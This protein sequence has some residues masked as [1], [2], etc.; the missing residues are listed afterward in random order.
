MV[1][2]GVH[3]T[4]QSTKEDFANLINYL[5]SN[6]T[7]PFLVTVDMEGCIN[8]FEN[9][10]NFTSLDR[11]NTT[12]QSFQ[13]GFDEGML[14]KELNMTINF[15]PVVD[16]ND[17]IWSCR[18]FLGT[19]QEIGDKASAYISGLQSQ[20]ILATAKHYPGKTLNLRDPHSVLVYA[21]IDDNDSLP[22]REVIQT[23]VSAIMVDHVIANG[24]VDSEVKQS[25]ASKRL[26]GDL[27]TNFSG[28]IITDE[29]SMLGLSNFYSNPDQVYI[30][31]FKANNDLVLY[32]NSDRT[33]LSHAISVVEEAVKS[34]QISEKR[35]DDSVTKILSIKGINVIS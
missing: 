33:K 2:G 20:G 12:N 10:Q 28:L 25:D 23:N 9:F 19:P 24:S 17:T 11:I 26:I 35:I 34:G 30:D 4:A 13:V 29:T 31:V 1:V 3:V 27:N 5:Q 16:L 8:P 6:A 32:L 14:M 21:T 15:S 18:S 22:F 7:I